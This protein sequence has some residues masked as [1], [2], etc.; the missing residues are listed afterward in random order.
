MPATDSYFDL[1]SSRTAWRPW[2]ERSLP[3][4]GGFRDAANLAGRVRRDAGL[5]TSE[6]ANLRLLCALAGAQ[7]QIARLGAREGL[8]EAMLAPLP[9]DRFGISVD[10]TPKGGWRAIAPSLRPELKRHRMRFRVC[11]ELGHA[12]F[13]SRGTGAPRRQVFDSPAQEEFCD[14]FGRHLLVPLGLAERMRPKTHALLNLQ[15]SCDVSLEVAARAAAA[16]Q[17]TLRLAIWFAA[18]KQDQG[19]VI[20]QWASPAAHTDPGFLETPAIQSEADTKWIPDRRQ[21]VAVG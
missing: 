18:P 1:N 19:G 8:Q 21:L 7:V 15:A 13:Y 17:P 5:R 6:P 14:A 12:L 9:N 11:H 16:A 4:V 10:P 3:A 2:G 20:L